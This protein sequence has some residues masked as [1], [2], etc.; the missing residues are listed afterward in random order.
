METGDESN[1]L[2]NLKSAMNPIIPKQEAKR[3]SIPNKSKKQPNDK[4]IAFPTSFTDIFLVQDQEKPLIVDDSTDSL[5]NFIDSIFV[6]LKKKC[7]I[8][9]FSP[10]RSDIFLMKQENISL[11]K[12][13]QDLE[14]ELKS[15]SLSYQSEIQEN[16]IKEKELLQKLEKYKTE[17]NNCISQLKNRAEVLNRVYNTYKECFLVNIKKEDDKYICSTF[18]ENQEIVFSFTS[19]MNY[20]TYNPIKVNFPPGS[21]LNYK[22]EDLNRNELSLLFT[23]LLKIIYSS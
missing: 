17:F 9:E 15:L 11:N 14:D 16:N 13:L 19:K 8:D 20:T 18:K 3:L 22:I 4:I 6:S 10:T 7:D 12:Y 21:F 1:Q 23:R 5:S 2:F